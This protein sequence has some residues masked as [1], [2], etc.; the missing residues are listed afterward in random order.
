M[1]RSGPKRE[2]FKTGHPRRR[3]CFTA[4]SIRQMFRALR[5]G[6]TECFEDKPVVHGIKSLVRRFLWELGSAP[7][8]LLSLAETG[9]S[10]VI[11]SQNLLFVALRPEGAF[12][13]LPT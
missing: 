4:S 3:A 7:V 10:G 8:R 6:K 9:G 5:F 2:G 11:L 12:E 13:D 1:P